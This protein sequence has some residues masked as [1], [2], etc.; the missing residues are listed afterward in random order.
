MDTPFRL[1]IVSRAGQKLFSL[2]ES[3][4]LFLLLFPML[5]GISFFKKKIIV[6]TNA[7]EFF[8]EVF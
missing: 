8:L 4:F 2:I 5:W 1:G 7:T 6:E 3:C